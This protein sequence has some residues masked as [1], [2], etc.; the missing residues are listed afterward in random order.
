MQV[1]I[2]N[3]STNY[4]TNCMFYA[5]MIHVQS[6]CQPDAD[7]TLNDDLCH[8]MSKSNCRKSICCSAIAPD[9]W[10]RMRRCPFW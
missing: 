4:V 1:H 8:S 2:H 7:Y 9:A 6:C 10:Q 3:Y 5:P